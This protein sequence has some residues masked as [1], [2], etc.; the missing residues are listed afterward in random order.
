MK[1]TDLSI[2]DRIE[3]PLLLPDTFARWFAS[4]GWTPRTHQLEL[5]G[6]AEAG[7]SA[8]LIAPTGGGKTL[9]GFLPTLVALSRKT[10]PR[11]KKR[12]PT[13]GAQQRDDA[14]RLAERVGADKM[15]SLGKHLHRMQQLCDLAFGI[16]R[17][18]HRQTE[19]C[20]GDEHIAGDR[21]ERRAGRVGDVFVI[22]GSDDARA[23]A[24][25]PDLGGTEHVAG[26]VKADFHAA[27]L[28][29]FAV[30]DRLRRAGE[31]VA[32]AQPHDVERFLRRQ[33]GAVRNQGLADRAG[34][35]D[36]KVA[37]LAT[38][39]GRRQDEDV[40]GPDVGLDRHRIRRRE[41]HAAGASAQ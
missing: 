15:R 28:E 32:V 8:L 6:K 21:L 12:V 5:L 3:T 29:G 1:V 33:Y 19:R 16:V 31:I 30:T 39:A 27:E 24:L 36:M 41:R 4:R 11:A 22:A 35:I 23:F 37:G 26:G 20:L 17:A 25:Y 9:A 2:S 7:R 34:R 18:E 10:V 13:G 14:L 40:S 38:Q